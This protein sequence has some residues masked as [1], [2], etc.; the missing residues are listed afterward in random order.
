MPIVNPSFEMSPDPSTPWEA[1]GWVY[2][3]AAA[4][5]IAGFGEFED[6]WDLFTWAEFVS[7]ISTGAP[8]LFDRWTTLYESFDFGGLVDTWSPGW[9]VSCG[10][11]FEW[12]AW[13]PVFHPGISSGYDDF[14]WSVFSDVFNPGV[15]CL[16]DAGVNTYEGFET[17]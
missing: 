12:T 15:V 6:P 10:D 5:I 4:C 11:D 3:S 17:W 13:D 16:F 8:A 9:L 7:D 14:I 1:T 2:T